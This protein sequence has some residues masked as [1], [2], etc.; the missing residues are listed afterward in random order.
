MKALLLPL[1]LIDILGCGLMAGLFFTFS[2]FAMT[3]FAKLPDSQGNAAMQQINVAILNPWFMGIF[4]GTTILSLASAI[5]A[6]LNWGNPGSVWLLA[7]SL[8]YLVGCFLV[9]AACNVP[10]NNAL[11]ATTPDSV[12]GI[13]MWQRY[14]K[15]WVPWNHLRTF[16]T[17]AGTGCFAMAIRY[18]P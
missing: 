2:N 13:A 3:A 8:F 12:E 7:G 10:L 5:L 14:L 15:E 17:I 11:A 1:S 6:I 9:T 16:A 4:M 18:L